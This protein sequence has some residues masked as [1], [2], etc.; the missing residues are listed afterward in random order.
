LGDIDLVVPHQASPVALKLMARALGLGE[1]R[2]IDLSVV[3]G[4]QVAA[5]LPITLDHARRAG[6]IAPGAR[7]LMLGT[8]A[9]V[10]FGTAL[11][12]AASSV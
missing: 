12:E 7:V 2:L 1:D 6:R 3:H 8:A 11:L 4:N 10:T 5:S 9:G